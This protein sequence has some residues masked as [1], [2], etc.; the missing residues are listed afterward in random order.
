MEINTKYK[1]IVCPD[2]GNKDKNQF[3]IIIDFDEEI[4]E[5]KF[6]C[7]KCFEMFILT[8]K[9]LENKKI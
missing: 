9:E 8:Y 3:D 2:C 7:R 5:V 4:G 6:G 1:N